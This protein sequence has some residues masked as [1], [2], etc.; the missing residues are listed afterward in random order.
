MT[1]KLLPLAAATAFT[2][3][4]AQGALVFTEDFDVPN[5]IP[6]NTNP[7]VT[8]FLTGTTTRLTDFRF[9]ARGTAN[10][11][12]NGGNA[13]TRAAAFNDFDGSS[14]IAPTAGLLFSG[15]PIPNGAVFG[16]NYILFADADGNN[17]TAG[18]TILA[19]ELTDNNADGIWQITDSATLLGVIYDDGLSD[20]FEFT[21][22]DETAVRALVESI[23]EPSSVALLGLAGLGF[24]GRR[25][26]A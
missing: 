21:A 26:R 2:L 6:T 9:D 11:V 14:L 22:A 3:P 13:Q 24:L 5:A 18:Q 10:F 1:K 17:A 25:K 12:W 8:A 15:S 20:T 19:F 4:Q 23:P 7:P 16:I